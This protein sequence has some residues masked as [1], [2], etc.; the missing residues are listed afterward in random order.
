VF[1]D[2]HAFYREALRVLEASGYPFL[3]GGAYALRHYTGIER[4]TRDFDVFVRQEHVEGVLERFRAQGYEVELTFSHW[5]AKVRCDGRYVDVI[6]SSGNGVARV[7]ESWFE[8]A[9]EGEVLGER[10]RLVPAE[11]MI[12]SKAFIMERE[13]FDGADV[14]HLIRA[15]ARELDWD[16]LIARFGPHGRVLLAHIVLFGYIYPEE[17]ERV[18]EQAMRAL[19]SRLDEPAVTSTGPACQG[20]LLSRSQYLPDLESGYRDPRLEDGI[21]T[22]DEVEAWTEAGRREHAQDTPRAASSP[23]PEASP[24][25]QKA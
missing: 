21:M 12:W 7:D 5:L 8:H 6:F 3:V 15:R 4:D 1:E 17:R 14:A 24:R 13:R 10:V 2:E 11:E 25:D 18:P 16:R 23:S 20:T 22:S 9:D 19:W